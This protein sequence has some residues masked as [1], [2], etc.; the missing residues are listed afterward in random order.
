MAAKKEMADALGTTK[1]ELA[2]LEKKVTMMKS[3]RVGVDTTVDDIY[4]A[5]PD[6]KEEV[7]KEIDNH[8]WHK[9]IA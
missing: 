7:H 2:D 9:D 4:E 5:Y 8:E 3:K 6:I 1:A